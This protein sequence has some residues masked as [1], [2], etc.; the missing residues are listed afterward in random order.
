[1]T[2][3]QVKKLCR[4]CIICDDDSFDKKWKKMVCRRAGMQLDHM[5]GL[6]LICIRGYFR[7]GI[8]VGLNDAGCK[9]HLEFLVL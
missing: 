9:R 1:M 7:W 2:E 5:T 8:E 4:G 6:P 3:D